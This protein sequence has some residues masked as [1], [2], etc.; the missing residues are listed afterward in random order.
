VN[1]RSTYVSCEGADMSERSE[2]VIKRMRFAN[3][4]SERS[5]EE[6]A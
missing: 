3:A 4:A 2:R 5:D 6:A 1:A